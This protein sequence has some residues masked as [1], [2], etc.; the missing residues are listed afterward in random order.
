MQISIIF[1]QK[2]QAVADEAWEKLRSTGNF[3]LGL[4][5]EVA[6]LRHSL[7]ESQVCAVT[8]VP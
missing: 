3:Q 4:E 8:E 1:L 2:T 5:A 6:E 7:A